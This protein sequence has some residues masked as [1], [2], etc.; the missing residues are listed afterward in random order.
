MK[1]KNK[2]TEYRFTENVFAFIFVLCGFWA[3][4]MIIAR[5]IDNNPVWYIWVRN[6]IV[7]MAI[8]IGGLV[9][10]KAYLTHPENKLG[11][12]K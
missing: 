1:T 10:S 8:L 5:S 9:V 7:C 6:I 12:Q 11:E 4:V 3:I 2:F